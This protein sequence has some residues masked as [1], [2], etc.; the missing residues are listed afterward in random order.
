MKDN[1]N[2]KLVAVLLVVVGALNWGLYAFDFNLVEALL[3][4][5]PVVESAVYVLVALAGLF[6]A[7]DT[8]QKKA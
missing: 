4:G 5:F 1:K 7:Y 3:G 2:V 6:V 8:F